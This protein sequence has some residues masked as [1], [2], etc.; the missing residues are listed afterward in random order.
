MPCQWSDPQQ[1]VLIA[2]AILAGLDVQAASDP[3]AADVDNA[4]TTTASEASAGSTSG[5]TDLS[6]TTGSSHDFGGPLTGVAVGA[7]VLVAYLAL[8]SRI[9]LSRRGESAAPPFDDTGMLKAKM[10]SSAVYVEHAVN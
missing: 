9:S 10:D 1:F 4:T 3:T 2:L 5:I 8:L 7:V 6:E